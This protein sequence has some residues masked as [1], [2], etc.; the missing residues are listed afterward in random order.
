V[1]GT[2][3]NVANSA[4]A[5]K[6]GLYSR[7][8]FLFGLATELLEKL[9][10]MEMKIST[11][12]GNKELEPNHSSV[13]RAG[14]ISGGITKQVIPEKFHSSPFDDRQV[15]IALIIDDVDRAADTVLGVAAL[16]PDYLIEVD[17]VAV[18]DD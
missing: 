6:N 5:N 10:A 12:Y 2:K 15:E 7:R 18:V 16:S 13:K 3:N 9:R 8:D 11:L 4:E 17:A 1:R 14:R